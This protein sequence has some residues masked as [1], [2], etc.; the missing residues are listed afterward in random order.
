MTGRSAV[1]KRF[2]LAGMAIPMQ[3]AMEIVD[4]RSARRGGGQR[5]AVDTLG[6][7]RA[8]RAP[9]RR[10]VGAVAEQRVDPV[11]RGA[12]LADRFGHRLEARRAQRS[13]VALRGGFRSEERL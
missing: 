3:A 13:L 2:R 8:G 12:R 11:A 9:Q 1:E 5:A 4:R 7:R 10:D 6:L